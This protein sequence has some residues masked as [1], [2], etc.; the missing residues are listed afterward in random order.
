VLRGVGW[1]LI[2]LGALVGLYL[3]YALVFTNLETERAQRDL[4]ERWEAAVGAVTVDDPEDLGARASGAGSAGEATSGSGS[5][6]GAAGG[7]ESTVDPVAAETGEALA[8]LQFRRPGGQPPVT[9]DAVYVVEGASVEALK[10]GPG[11]YPDTA[12]P[13]ADGNFAVAGHRTTYGAP[14]FDLDELAGG[15]EVL[16]TDRAGVRHT[17][18]VVETR[19]VA[20]SDNWVLADDPLGTGADGMLTLTTC[21]PRFSAAQRMI[22]F[23]EL[24][25]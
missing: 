4:S 7:A 13:G 8:V 16:V 1:T 14:F 23:A 3:V 18:R 11:H 24:V 10:R 19:I 2:G 12:A 15:D 5:D 17:Y 9:D 6:E 22:V 25:A 21:H 20:P